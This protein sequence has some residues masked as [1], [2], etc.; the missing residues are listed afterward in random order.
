MSTVDDI[1][2]LCNLSRLEIPD[3]EIENTSNKIKEILTFFDKIDEL[4][5]EDKKT[6]EKYEKLE[7][8]LDELREDTLNNDLAKCDKKPFKFLYEKNGYVIGP[9]I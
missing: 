3:T 6:F 2:K 7:K 9:R 4:K 1:K 8:T 5:I